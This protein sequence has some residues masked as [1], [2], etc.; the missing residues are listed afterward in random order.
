MKT[1]WNDF[2]CISLLNKW[3]NGKNWK[4]GRKESVGKGGEERKMQHER[5]EWKSQEKENKGKRR[6]EADGEEKEEEN[7]GKRSIWEERKGEKEK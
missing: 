5:R 2:L 3:R 6:R 4:S 1:I 7:G